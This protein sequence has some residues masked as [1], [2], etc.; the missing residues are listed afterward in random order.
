MII[1]INYTN[2]HKIKINRAIKLVIIIAA[3]FTAVALLNTIHIY[4]VK[5]TI[6]DY[7]ISREASFGIPALA[8]ISCWLYYYTYK[9]DDLYLMSLVFVSLACEYVCASLYSKNLGG[10]S[11]VATSLIIFTYLFRAL[12]V[13][14][15]V[16]PENK[17]AKLIIKR[18]ILFTLITVIVTA[19]LSI[20]SL[21][22]LE[23]FGHNEP[24]WISLFVSN[25][26]LSIYHF[27]I[28]I[29]IIRKS[30]K[31]NEFIYTIISIS[32][33]LFIIKSVYANLYAWGYRPIINEYSNIFSMGGYIILIVGIF[34]EFVL[35]VKES[36][37]LHQKLLVFYA[38]SEEDRYNDIVVRDRDDKIVY[39]NK[40]VRKQW[41]VDRTEKGYEQLNH[42]LLNVISV[43]QRLSAYEYV[44]NNKS[45]WNGN[46]FTNDGRVI[47]GSLQR[48]SD[49]YG[50]IYNVLTT[51]DITDDYNVSHEL[52][53]N[54][55]RLRLITKN[56]KDLIFTVDMN[57]VINY[58]NTTVSAMLG[59]DEKELIGKN[60]LDIVNN[61]DSESLSIMIE[62]GDVSTFIEHKL[63]GKN[64]KLVAVESVIS[65][66]RD[67]Y[68][69]P[70][71]KVI[72]SRGLQHR[73]AI[74]SLQ[75]KYREV[76]QYEQIRNEFFANL[77]HEL[78]TPINII[79]SCIQLLDY[80][81]KNSD[82][83]GFIE[84][85]DKYY[86]S[87]QQ[88]CFR[89]LRLVNNLIDIT[90]IDSGFLKMDFTNYDIVNL[91]E[92]ITMSIVPYVEEKQINIIFDTEVEE[93]EI[94]CDP[95]KIERVVLNLLSNAV[96][97][98]ETGGNID[99]NIALVDD[100]KWVEISVKDDGI[101]I[102][103]HMR[104][105]IFE[106]FIQVDKSYNRNKEGSGIGLALV[107][108]LVEL[109]GGR[110]YLKDDTEKGCNFIVLLPN[111]I[112]ENV[113]IKE[114]ESRYKSSVDRISIEF[115]DIYELN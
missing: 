39:A 104:K 33:D 112:E 45:G 103:K 62:E 66:I 19:L 30:L 98:T 71:G 13:T 72:V 111:V 57:G 36:R 94:R 23:S 20:G 85:Y 40:K 21:K 91:V 38:I 105:F 60:Y 2:N 6:L 90:K 16:V 28:I 70:I 87:M 37:E 73:N 95:D 100:N 51:R 61:T 27:I 8:I 79:Y 32:L 86:K 41:G 11:V 80:K 77:S 93:L 110:V 42:N 109:H 63:V 53:V 92:D 89:M 7:I 99:V 47:R 54:E 22:M 101:G 4:Q 76:K 15:V 3:I 56:I 58:V 113:V 5:N 10:L 81:K 26:I 74:R 44:K 115:A 24:L 64:D 31:T 49:E 107:K 9:K 17:L 25:I 106:R 35:K 34:I 114:K 83:D 14:L 69:E 12:F 46:F 102:P 75:K 65:T 59:Y 108:S 78:R 48:L 55:E 50:C 52:K 67:Y 18:K 82:Q 97:F 29:M 43:D 96:K 84:Y 88:N 1:D 68:E